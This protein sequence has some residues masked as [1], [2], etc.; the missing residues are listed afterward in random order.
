MGKNKNW[1]QAEKDYLA[2]NW[3]RV[4]IPAMSKHLNR[5]VNAIMDM[6]TRLQLGAYFDSGEYITL[7]QLMLAIGYGGSSC[8]YAVKSWVENRGLPAKHKLRNNTRVW[9]V[10]LDDFWEWAEKNQGFLDFSKF[11][12]NALGV[13]PDWA[14]RKRKQDFKTL[15]GTKKIAWTSYEDERLKG[16]LKQHRYSFAELSKM[17][18]R[19]EGAI[20]RRITDLKLKERPVKADKNNQWTSEQISL[21]GRLIKQGYSYEAIHEK[22]PDK[23]TKA[24]RGYVFRFYLTESLDKVRNYIGSGEFGDNMP[25]RKLYQRNCMSIEERAEVKA[26]VSQLAYLL[27]QRARQ[28][29][30]VAEEYKNYWQ[31]DMCMN[32]SDIHGCTAGEADCDSCASFIRIQPQFC[33]RCGCTFFETRTSDICQKCRIAR[34]KQ[35]QRKYAVLHRN[36]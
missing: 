19:T 30:P 23:S 7:R 20:Q 2:E 15:K 6:R 32:W 12:E 34:F 9:V 33:K 8:K 28:I 10:Y 22:I 21:L 27:N 13:E 3:G 16:L 35:A 4:S 1:T 26:G 25:P 11:P 14:K 29:S 24:I 18:G 31:K 36:K 17:L 5:S